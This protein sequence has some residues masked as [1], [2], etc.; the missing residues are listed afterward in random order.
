M[1]GIFVHDSFAFSGRVILAC[2]FKSGEIQAF[3]YGPKPQAYPSYSE[4][5]K[6]EQNMGAVGT[7]DKLYAW[8][9]PK[10]LKNWKAHCYKNLEHSFEA[11]EN[12]LQTFIPKDHEVERLTGLFNFSPNSGSSSFTIL[13][14]TGSGS[15]LSQSLKVSEEVG[16]SNHELSGAVSEKRAVIR[17]SSGKSLW[18]LYS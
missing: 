1:K 8:E 11:H 7:L 16:F 14:L 10:M 6:L 4:S 9:F 15:I 13:Q 18:Q 12:N 2:A 17:T 3:L 5:I